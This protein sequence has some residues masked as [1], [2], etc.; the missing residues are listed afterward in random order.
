MNMERETVH[1]NTNIRDVREC[2]CD[3]KKHCISTYKSAILKNNVHPVV[4]TAASLA[5]IYFLNDV[6]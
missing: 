1:G 5:H 4:H 6:I 2:H 3:C